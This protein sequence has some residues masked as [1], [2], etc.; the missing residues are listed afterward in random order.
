M[1]E[2]KKA[3]TCFSLLESRDSLISGSLDKTIR[4]W[5]IIL[6]EHSF[7]HNDNH[8]ISYELEIAP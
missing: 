1:K 6:Q 3:V 7:L 8:T 2:H 5:K 4:V